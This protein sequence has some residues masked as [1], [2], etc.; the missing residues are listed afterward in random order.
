VLPCGDYCTCDTITS[1]HQ[2]KAGAALE[3]AGGH[4]NVKA[5]YADPR[6]SM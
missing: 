3:L 4:P 1:R 5:A 6:E 2:D